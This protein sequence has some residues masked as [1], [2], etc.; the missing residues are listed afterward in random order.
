MELEELMHEYRACCISL[1]LEQID[2]LLYETVNYILR[3]GWEFLLEIIF[4]FD[5]DNTS[6]IRNGCLVIGYVP[7]EEGFS[8]MIHLSIRDILK[9]Q[10]DDE[11]A[12]QEL[13]LEYL[14][15]I[16]PLIP[17]MEK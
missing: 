6:D 15:R 16:L 11:E 10:I 14:K 17:C 4:T 2:N 9:R 12:G 3:N 1:D 13:K 8:R 7:Y 5:E